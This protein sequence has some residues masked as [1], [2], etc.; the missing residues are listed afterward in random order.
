[1]QITAADVRRI[2]IKAV[3][4]QGTCV[5]AYHN[6]PPVKGGYRALRDENAVGLVVP[7]AI[8]PASGA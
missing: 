3:N 4:R 1:V 6:I 2:S 5:Q 7:G 8:A